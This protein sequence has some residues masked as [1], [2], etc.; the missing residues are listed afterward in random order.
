MAMLQVQRQ[1]V[2][3]QSILQAKA[4]PQGKEQG[5]L[6]YKVYKANPSSLDIEPCFKDFSRRESTDLQSKKKQEE[7]RRKQDNTMRDLEL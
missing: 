6:Q 3:N 5:H 7:E 2:I 1:M 4:N